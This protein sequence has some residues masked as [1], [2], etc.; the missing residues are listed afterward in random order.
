MAKAD[1]CRVD[2]WLWRARFFKT[3]ALAASAVEA[4]DVRV[5]RAGQSRVVDKPAAA[6]G[7]GDGL[8]IR[9]AR[10]L[11]V[12]EVVALGTRRGPPA[13]ARGLYAS[14][15]ETSDTSDIGDS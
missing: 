12:V 2:V 1:R 6:I 13:E 4:G 11:V 8:S 10:S 9:T 3:R 14:D 5:M 7:V 15:E